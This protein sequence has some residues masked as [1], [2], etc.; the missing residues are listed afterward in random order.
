MGGIEHRDPLRRN[1][2]ENR[3]S[4][5]VLPVGI[6]KTR[7]DFVGRLENIIV[8]RLAVFVF[9]VKPKA[10]ACHETVTPPARHPAAFV[11]AIERC[12]VA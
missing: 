2:V 5:A 11:D 8:K 7:P 1:G 9:V 3:V 12:I 10:V 4:R 6:G